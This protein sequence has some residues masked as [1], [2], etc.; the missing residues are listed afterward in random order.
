MIEIRDTSGDQQCQQEIASRIFTAQESAA[1]WRAA[2]ID[3]MQKVLDGYNPRPMTSMSG[4]ADSGG[5]QWTCLQM[6]DR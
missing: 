4:L 3:D 5:C 2:Y 6:T 1:R